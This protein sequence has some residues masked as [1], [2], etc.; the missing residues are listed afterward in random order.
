MEYKRISIIGGAGSGKT[1]LANK[2]GAEL[3][4]PVCHI[5]GIQH[6]ENWKMRDPEE[7][8]KIILEKIN[9]DKWIMDGTYR[10]TLNERV[11]RADL[12]IFLDYSS[13]AK[14]KGIIIR[15]LKN[16]NKEKPEI[17]GCKEK[18]DWDFIKWTLDWNKNK[19]EFVMDVLNQNKD[20][21]ILIFKNRRKLNKWYKNELRKIKV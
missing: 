14:L 20:K 19:R 11:K 12:T 6:L 8:D 16:P 4:L 2:L 9:E 3:N 21:N 15:F 1:T 17:P 7:R 5:D 18:I 13:I 10:M